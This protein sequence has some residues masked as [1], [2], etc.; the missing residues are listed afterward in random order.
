MP[1]EWKLDFQERFSILVFLHRNRGKRLP[2]PSYK[3]LVLG[4]NKDGE[5]EQK[6][7]RRKG[8][9]RRNSISSE[10]SV[11]GLCA[12]PQSASPSF[13]PGNRR[14]QQR[15]SRWEMGQKRARHHS[16]QTNSSFI[17]ELYDSWAENGEET[18]ADRDQGW[19]RGLRYEGSEAYSLYRGG[20][21]V[22]QSLSLSS[23]F[24][25]P[26]D[27][28]RRQRNPPLPLV[29]ASFSLG[30]SVA[31]VILIIRIT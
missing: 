31:G 26:E 24:S 8:K 9:G 18:K 19:R 15:T 17:D 22:I 20:W 1:F 4:G 23:L 16:E 11:R 27:T 7:L 14:Q 10:N 2:V 12:V 21:C 3:K 6:I 29:Y 28:N 25:S 5:G 30:P 13:L